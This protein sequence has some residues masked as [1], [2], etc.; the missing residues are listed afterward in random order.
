MKKYLLFSVLSVLL[1][2]FY[3]V[4]AQEEQE[5][6]FWLENANPHH[7]VY[8]LY[9]LNPISVGYNTWE[10]YYFKFENNCNLD[11]HDKVSIDWSFEMDGQ[12]IDLILLQQLGVEIEMKTKWGDYS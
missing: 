12:P 10:Y 2:M 6:C 1:S 3:V 9:S 7:P 5:C 11:P 4:Q 8:D